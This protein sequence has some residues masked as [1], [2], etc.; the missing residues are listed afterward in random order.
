MKRAIYLSILGMITAACIVYGV[1]RNFRHFIFNRT[2]YDSGNTVTLEG[3]KLEAF[4]KMDFDVE[5]LGITIQEGEDYTISY[6]TQERLIP[7]YRVENGTL[8]VKQKDTI[9]MNFN[10]SG[11]MRVIVTV[12]QGVC[13]EDIK[14]ESD[15]GDVNIEEVDTKN[16]TCEADVGDINA[17]HTC[18]GVTNI[19]ADVGDIDIQDAVLENAN[20]YADVG[21]IDM[22]S[23]TLK[24]T[25]VRAE[26][27]NIKIDMNG[28]KEDYDLELDTEDGDVSVDGKHH[29]S[30]IHN[31][32][33]GK[34]QLNA[35]ADMGEIW[36]NFK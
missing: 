20:I 32:N 3:E 7:E 5:L 24:D 29:G 31:D 33:D 13:L 28:A 26:I 14:A 6:T 10:Y 22:R 27:G 8:Y 9:G 16:F 36:V 2:G 35:F 12:P 25:E 18:L 19:T 34:Y 23:V 11:R 30:F 21:D 17:K 1:I 4:E 15:V